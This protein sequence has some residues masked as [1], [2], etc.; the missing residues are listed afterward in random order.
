MRRVWLAGAF[1]FWLVAGAN[2]TA[3]AQQ[4]SAGPNQPSIMTEEDGPSSAEQPARAVRGGGQSQAPALDPD[5]DAADQLAPSQMRQPMPAAVPEP[6]GTGRARATRGTALEPG[7][8]ARPSAAAKPDNV[9]CNGAFARD[10]SHAKLAMAFQS[11]NVAFTQVD[12]PS[13]AKIMATVIFAKDPKRRLE[14]WWNNPASRSGTHLI[15]INSVSNWTAAGQLHLGLTLPQLEQINGKPFKLSGFDK[16]NVAT[17]TDWNGGTLSA[18][19]GGCKVG[20][21]LRSRADS[22]LGALPANREFTSTDTAM[23]AVNPEVSEILIAY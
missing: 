8:E 1:L 14:V 6:T 2:S 22:A 19:S 12:G 21:S 18:V 3:W 13:G 7:V 4:R 17:L 11:R 15:V 5:L 23:R 20:V 16:S 9:A 10:S